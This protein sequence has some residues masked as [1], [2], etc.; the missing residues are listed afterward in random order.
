MINYDI[1]IQGTKVISEG[2]YLWFQIVNHDNRNFSMKVEFSR[3]M[4]SF[5]DSKPV[6]SKAVQLNFV[7]FDLYVNQTGNLYFKAPR[8]NLSR[9]VLVPFGCDIP[10]KQAVFSFSATDMNA[11]SIHWYERTE[12]TRLWV[13]IMPTS[14]IM[15][16]YESILPPSTPPLPQTYYQYYPTSEE[17]LF[18]ACVGLLCGIGFCCSIVWKRRKKR[19]KT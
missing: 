19:A 14:W 9:P 6:A 12:K 15:E 3:F 17:W 11:T 7:A 4:F 1:E 10:H 13:R 2:G 18:L 8:L 16:P 5:N